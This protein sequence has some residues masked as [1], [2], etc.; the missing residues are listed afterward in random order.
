M[1]TAT[2]M[3]T[4]SANRDYMRELVDAYLFKIPDMPSEDLVI[5]QIKKSTL[6]DLYKYVTKYNDS[7][8]HIAVYFKK[9]RIVTALLEKKMYVDYPNH[10]NE[11]PLHYSLF[12]Y[13]PLSYYEDDNVCI[14]ETL[15]KHGANVNA[16]TMSER[17]G[18]HELGNFTPLRYALTHG[19][20][21]YIH[22]L[23]KHGAYVT[24]HSISKCKRYIQEHAYS[25]G[26]FRMLIEIKWSLM[27]EEYEKKLDDNLKL[28]I[29]NVDRNHNIYVPKDLTNLIR[30]FMGYTDEDIEHI[31]RDIEIEIEDRR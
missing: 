31:I 10:R 23:I 2:T 21:K 24:F 5:E 3:A 14:V 9:H 15:I 26:E 12:Y 29:A 22:C 28:V 1:S 13:R 7:I 8:L 18:Y 27:K 16:V 17:Y 6:D 20:Y 19:T 11:T 30:T 25:P 4:S